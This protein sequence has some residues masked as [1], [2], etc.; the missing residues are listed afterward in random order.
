MMCQRI[1]LLPISIIGFGLRPLSSLMRVPIPP[2]RITAFMACPP[3]DERPC[4]PLMGHGSGALLWLSYGVHWALRGSSL[5]SLRR[6]GRDGEAPSKAVYTLSGLLVRP[7]TTGAKRLG[8]GAKQ[9][10]LRASLAGLRCRDASQ[11]A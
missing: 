2:A 8:Q 6:G 9:A 5:S 10:R 1:G 11:S 4:V 7:P 3:R